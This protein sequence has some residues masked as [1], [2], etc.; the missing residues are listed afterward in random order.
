MAFAALVASPTWA[1]GLGPV[2]DGVPSAN[3]RLPS[4]SLS[5]ID[6]DFRTRLLAAGTDPLENPSGI[7]T[8]YGYLSDGTLTHPDENTYLVLKNNPGGPTPG[9]DYGRRFLFQGHE[10]F[11]GN[12]AYVTRINLD[13]PRGDS[14]RITLLTP[15]N[16]KTGV[17]GLTSIDGSTYD[18]FTNTLLFT[19]EAGTSGGAVQIDAQL[20]APGQ[21]LWTP[22]SAKPA[23]RVFIPT[24]RATS[25]S[26]RTS[27]ARRVR[28]NSGQLEQGPAAEFLRLPLC[29]E[30]AQSDRR[31]RKA[32]SAAGDRRRDAVVFGG[33]SAAARDADISSDAQLKLHTPGKHYPIKWVTIHTA[34]PGDSAGFDANAAAKA[35]GATPFKRPENMAWLPGSGFRTFFFDPTG[36]T[37]SVAG[38]NPFLQARGAYGAIF[39]VDLR[40]EG[41]GDDDVDDHRRTAP[42]DDGRISLFFL[43]D[44]DHNSFDNLSF[45][46]KKQLLATED[47]GDTLHTQLNTLDSVWAFNVNSGKAI[48]FIA[49]GRDATSIAHGEDNEP[50]GIY[51]SNGSSQK[52]GLLGT[53]DSLDEARDSS[54]SSTATTTPMSS[55][56]PAASTGNPR[57]R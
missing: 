24:T 41:D 20:A 4:T 56:A 28:P 31:W 13:V 34:N 11:A 48:R 35:A 5:L 57:S 40:T 21:L 47:R 33:T 14:H 50:T 46:N 6:P 49:L 12:N 16:A 27:A 38:E 43:G 55:S 9:Y 36:D 22:F 17:T 53:E 8:Q 15:V 23:M 45:I 52:D 1:D 25:T 26:S 42:A 30:Q 3:A 29:S 18:P 32:A 39:R 44:H 19:Q 51:V 54:P 7:I 37:D 10:L 2:E